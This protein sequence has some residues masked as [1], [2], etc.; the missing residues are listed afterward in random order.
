MLP[1]MMLSQEVVSQLIVFIVF[2][3]NDCQYWTFLDFRWDVWEVE[4]HFAK[5][6]VFALEQGFVTEHLS[7]DCAIISRYLL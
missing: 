1:F 3:Y 7:Y 4:G 5:L 6:A 2:F